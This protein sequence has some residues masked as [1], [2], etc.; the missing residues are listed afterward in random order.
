MM[1]PPPLPPIVAFTFTIDTA[2]G[3]GQCFG[4]VPPPVALSM[5]QSL[6]IT[7]MAQEQRNGGQVETPAAVD[8]PSA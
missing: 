8:E 1:E 2:T 3:Q 6:V 5:L 7:I 4:N